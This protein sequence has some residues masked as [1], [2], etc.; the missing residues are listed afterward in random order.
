MNPWLNIKDSMQRKNC[1]RCIFQSAF[2]ILITCKSHPYI[3]INGSLSLFIFLNLL[4]IIHSRLISLW[5]LE[6][7]SRND[8]WKYENW[9]IRINQRRGWIVKISLCHLPYKKKSLTHKLMLRVW[10]NL[11]FYRCDKK[12]IKDIRKEGKLKV[13]MS[14]NCKIFH[15]KNQE[16]KFHRIFMRLRDIIFYTKKMCS[17]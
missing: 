1:E 3:W 17:H 5:K 15:E 2:S 14:R 12:Y 7:E 13:F 4:F 16:T 11:K 10:R 8:D 9:K 6:N